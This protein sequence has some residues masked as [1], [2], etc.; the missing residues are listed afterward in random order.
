MIEE[1]MAKAI[2]IPIL[3]IEQTKAEESEKGVSDS[4]IEGL[5]GLEQRASHSSGRTGQDPGER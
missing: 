1:Q 4:T 3:R 5:V 2:G